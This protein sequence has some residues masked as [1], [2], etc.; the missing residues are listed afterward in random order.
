MALQ[1][2]PISLNF[3]S[4]LDTKTS[5]YQIQM[6]KM[7]TLVN[8]VFNKQGDLI[9]RNG[10]ALLTTTPHP[11]T[12][13]PQ[14]SSYSA[15]PAA[16]NGASAQA[17]DTGLL[18]QGVGTIWQVNPVLTTLTSL[19]NNLIATGSNL[20]AFSQDTSQ[21]FNKGVIQPVQLS[22]LPLVRVSTSQT[23]PDAAI[24]PNGLC[25]T[26]YVD[27]S[28]GYY[29]ISDS[30]TGQQI[31]ARTSLGS[32]STNPRVF[33]FSQYFIITYMITISATTHLQYIAI[34]YSSPTNPLAAR[35]LS[36][37]VTSL[38]TGYDAYSTSQGL[39]YAW[40]HSG[41]VIDVAFLTLS[42]IAL[43]QTPTPTAISGSH[44]A[45]LLSIYSDLIGNAGQP[46]IWVTW[47]DG[48]NLWTTALSSSLTSILSPTE[49]VTSAGTLETITSIASTSVASTS[50]GISTL[51]VLYENLNHYSDTGAYPTSGVKT[52]YISSITC[53]AGGSIGSPGVI[54]RS[55]GLA[56][57][58]FIG[59]SGIIYCLAAYG[60]LNYD[61]NSSGAPD[62]FTYFLIDSL[63]NIYSRL[64]YSNGGGY[65]AT[66]VLPNVSLL[67][68]QYY[69]PYL[70]N[71][72]LAS[73]NKNT[74]SSGVTTSSIYTQTGINLAAFGINNS[75]QYSS[76]IASA[77]HL[78]GGQLWEYD[79]VKPVE[80]GFHVWPDNVAVTTATGSGSITAGTYYYQF[81]YEWTDNQ[82]NLHRSAPSVPVTITTTTSSS[83]NTI[84]VPTL[85]LTYK[86]PP[87]PVRI[88]GYRWSVAQQVYYQFSSITSPKINDPTVDYVT[89]TDTLADSSILG[90][91]I[92]YTTG[93]VIENIAAPASVASCLF[94][95]RL[96]IID[97]EDR[98]LLWFSKQVIEATPVEM[99]DLLT[100]YVAPS[101]G[102]Q[103]ST[104]PMTALGA[105]DDKLIIFKKDASYYINGIGPDNTGN[106][107]QY[108]DPVYITS[109]VGCTNPNSIV[110]TPNG[111]MFQS[112]K[113]IW[114]LGRDLSTQY[115]GAPVEQYNGYVVKS[116]QTIPGTNQVRFIL[117]NNVTLLY[118]YYYG[119]WGTFTNIAAISSVI[120]NGYQT[121]LNSYGQVLQETPNTWVDNST[122]VLMSFTTG[123]INAAG[124]QGYERFYA[125][126]LLGTY[127]SPFTLN[128]GFSYDYNPSILYTPTVKPDN[129]APAYGVLPVYGAGGPYGGA[130]N[131]NGNVFTARVFPQQQKC[132]SFQL[133]VNEIYDASYGVP[134]GQG[135]TF[136]GLLLL[137]GIK[138]G[139][140]TQ[141]ASKSFG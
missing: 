72:L 43:N 70:A 40:S 93:G 7:L 109:S 122:P 66:Q 116:A 73:V 141:S 14:Y 103:G 87:N 52:D 12:G 9:K 31:L 132:S 99:S 117:N 120:Y 28:V 80:H 55:V 81:C 108:S 102:T 32:T 119:Q 137:L 65:T 115:I 96:W 8:G 61:I 10:N 49:L 33:L 124:L 48:T 100:L 41:T 67:N 15:F 59:P 1:K 97:A 101:T 76:E 5:P 69:I 91:V 56:S 133:T 104:G 3:A 127:Y 68:N 44:T 90:N 30:S 17:Q 105:M 118:D 111:L 6:G 27:N 84:Y 88:V 128:V 38:T 4:G 24:A 79:G 113:G 136:S 57:K 16:T 123:W 20:Y 98:N 54:L 11:T 71:D 64:A 50:A 121:Y 131:A 107:S 75:G 94:N 37:T 19:N 126:N 35:D 114:L 140:R 92:L 51:T 138:R 134:A 46:L 95:N 26:V 42:N 83:T 29:Q 25:C 125:C 86:I 22:T 13:A 21:W 47:F 89:F 45:T 82:G 139:S 23:S 53:T 85:R 2:Q 129:Y 18:Y 135:L 62:Q 34:P 106:N 58:A 77:L 78:T 39:Y 110:L 60:E 36:T 130:S 74:N 112:D 63:G